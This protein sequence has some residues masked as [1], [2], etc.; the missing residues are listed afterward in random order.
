MIY[1]RNKV[2]LSEGNFQKWDSE[3]DGYIV[4]FFKLRLPMSKTYPNHWLAWFESDNYD[5]APELFDKEPSIQKVE[6]LYTG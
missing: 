3:F 6:E 5:Y 4:V 2:K 1:N